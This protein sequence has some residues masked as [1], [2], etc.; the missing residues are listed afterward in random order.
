MH[1]CHNPGE[2]CL[3]RAHTLRDLDQ[4]C[5]VVDE[6][7]GTVRVPIVLNCSKLSWRIAVLGIAGWKPNVVLKR[8]VL[9]WHA[10]GS[11]GIIVAQSGKLSEDD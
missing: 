8:T 11:I 2:T 4:R 7:R 9:A 6:R 5:E 3:I 1:D 10:R